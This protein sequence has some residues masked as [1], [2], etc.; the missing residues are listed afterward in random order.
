MVK[1]VVKKNLMGVQKLTTVGNALGITLPKVVLKMAG[2]KKG[3]LLEI[4]YYAT[5][6][7]FT[8]RNFSKKCSGKA[9]VV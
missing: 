8:V 9:E 3:D 1:I 7:A 4:D 2:W 6:D 5:D